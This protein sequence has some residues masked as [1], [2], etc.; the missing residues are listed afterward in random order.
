M[1]ADAEIGKFSHWLK[2]AEASM[3]LITQKI[4][5]LYR[6]LSKH[7]KVAYTQLEPIWV[8]RKLPRVHYMYSDWE[9]GGADT[10]R[11]SSKASVTQVSRYGF[12]DLW[13]SIEVLKVI[14]GQ[15]GP[16]LFKLLLG[17]VECK[18]QW[19]YPIIGEADVSVSTSVVGPI[20]TLRII[21]KFLQ[22]AAVLLQEIF[23][24]SLQ[25]HKRRKVWYKDALVLVY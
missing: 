16:F 22:V 10:H 20:G 18:C 12:T 6:Q 24:R 3:L 13:C 5:T 7:F 17:F 15:I 23:R 1:S 11:N 2:T 25:H 19:P 8:N 21:A 9:Q 14:K 4:L